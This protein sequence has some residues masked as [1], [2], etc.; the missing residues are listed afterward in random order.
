[1]ST[2]TAAHSHS[3]CEETSFWARLPVPTSRRFTLIQ[4]LK[5]MICF[6]IGIGLLNLFIYKLSYALQVGKQ[7]RMESP[8]Y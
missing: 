2:T 3:N 6:Q 4:A 7:R 8:V 5:L 1:M